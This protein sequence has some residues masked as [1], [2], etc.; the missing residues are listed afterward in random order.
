M[1]EP[2]MNE[3]CYMCE[4]PATGREHVPPRCLFPEAKDLP[5]TNHRKNLIT[6]PSCDAH[7]SAKSKDDEYM[8][9]VV[10][11]FVLNDPVAKQ[12]VDSKVMRTLKRNPKIAA[13][14]VKGGDVLGDGIACMRVDSERIFRGCDYITRG[15]YYSKYTEKWES[16]IECFSTAFLSSENVGDSFAKSIARQEVVDSWFISTQQEQFWGDNLEIF[17]YRLFRVEEKVFACQFVF[18]GAVKF[19]CIGRGE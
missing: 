17:K 13:G 14:L 3:T 11:A 8:M 2:W 7:N 18:Y 15:L 9:A 19:S 10:S 16:R 5:G 1:K 12:H 6:V 4:A